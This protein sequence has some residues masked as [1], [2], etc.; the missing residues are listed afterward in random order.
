MS[1][2]WKRLVRAP[3]V[4]ALDVAFRARRLRMLFIVGHMRSGS[5]LLVHLLANSPEVLGFGE[6]QRRYATREDFARATWYIL[7]TFR[8]LVPRE[9]YVLDKVLHG[10]R[11]VDPAVLACA[12]TRTI[13]L[14]RRPE[15][16][17]SSILELGNPEWATEEVALRYYLERLEVVRGLADRLGPERCIFLTYD[18]MVDRPAET[19][20]DLTAFLGLAAPLSEEYSLMWSTGVRDLGDPSTA[21]RAGRILRLEPENRFRISADGLRRAADAYDQCVRDCRDALAARSTG[22]EAPR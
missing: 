7:R 12:G 8:R 16:A 15:R 19:L 2:A 20:S 1:A 13:L 22:R 11:L 10:W 4:R 18:Q 17:L 9:R 5:S 6:T 14:V 21:I 3:A